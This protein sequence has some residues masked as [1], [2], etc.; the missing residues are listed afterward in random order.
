[1][2]GSL[3]KDGALLGPLLLFLI[4]QHFGYTDV[5]LH[6]LVLLDVGSIVLLDYEGKS[7][8]KAEAKTV[9][10]VCQ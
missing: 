3:F 5:I 10:N 7:K 6:Q 8:K 1:M 9:F 4:L 2:S